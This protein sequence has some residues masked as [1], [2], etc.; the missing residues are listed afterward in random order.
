MASCGSSQE[1]D[2]ASG[3]NAADKISGATGDA[4]AAA[5]LASAEAIGLTAEEAWNAAVENAA[6]ASDEASDYNPDRDLSDRIEIPLG[7][8]MMY[9]N[10]S[11]MN[12]F[13]KFNEE[14]L[15]ADTYVYQDY[16]FYHSLTDEMREYITGC[17]YP[18]EG[19]REISLDGLAYVSVLHMDFDGY[20]HRGELICN[21]A[22][23]KD[24]VEIFYELFQNRY[25]I[26]RMILIDEY[27]GNDEYSMEDNNTT[28]FNYRM[29]VDTGSLSQHALGRAVDLNPLYNPYMYKGSVEP[30]GSEPY[31]DRTLNE[32]Y[33]IKDDGI[34]VKLFKEHGFEWGGDWKTMKDYQHFQKK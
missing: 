34:V 2:F 25:P 31:T 18:A 23:A 28:C 16:F 17:S 1:A 19:A 32:P 21:K 29:T 10:K 26:Q 15:P 14:E 22:I 3:E 7:D 30:V 8:S 12:Q 13:C 24:L 6:A 4:L 9:A 20:V 33:L 27:G 5:G 11:E